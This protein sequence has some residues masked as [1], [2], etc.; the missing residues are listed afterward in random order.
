[1]LNLK[2]EILRQ[3]EKVDDDTWRRFEY[4]LDDIYRINLKH[5]IVD[6]ALIEKLIFKYAKIENIYYQEKTPEQ[7]YCQFI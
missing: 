6:D 4:A 2:I 1:M 3:D 5:R 7:I